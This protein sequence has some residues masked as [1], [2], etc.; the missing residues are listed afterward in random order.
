VS[1]TDNHVPALAV[2]PGVLLAAREA[3]FFGPGSIE[4]HLRHAEGF[5]T[6]AKAQAGDGTALIL[7]LGSGGGLPGL[8]LANEWPAA[9]LVLLD[10]NERRTQFLERAVRTCGF[11]ERVRV[12]HER[13]EVAGRDPLYRG[14]FDGVVVRSFGP[15]SVVAECAAPLLRLGGWLIVSEPPQEAQEGSEGGVSPVTGPEGD[16]AQDASRWPAGGLAEFGLENI[17]TV[18]NEFG[19]QVMRQARW[20]PEKYPRRNGVPAKKPLF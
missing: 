20:C 5:I 7:D 2:L 17:E 8:V 1:S 10:A 12:V 18:R 16:A 13:A 9:R 19:Y 11:E 4:R 14:T 15:P 6:L 3:G